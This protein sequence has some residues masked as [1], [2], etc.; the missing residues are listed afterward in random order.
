M[1]KN[2]MEKKLFVFKLMTL[3]WFFTMGSAT[4][5]WAEDDGSTSSGSNSTEETFVY[6]FHANPSILAGLGT[7]ITDWTS[8][9]KHMVIT[10]N[11][12]QFTLHNCLRT[13][14]GKSTCLTIRGD[15]NDNNTGYDPGYVQGSMKGTMTQMTLSTKSNS[16]EGDVSI[17]IEASD[18]KMSEIKQHIY[19]NKD[20]VI[21]IPAD[22]QI[23]DAKAITIQP[24]FKLDL[25]KIT[26]TRSNGSAD[27]KDPWIIF[28]T[29][30]ANADNVT[31]Y[32]TTDTENHYAYIGQIL[33]LE[34]NGIEGFDPVSTMANPYVVTYTVD[35][36]EPQFTNVM[37]GKKTYWKNGNDTYPAGYEGHQEGEAINMNGYVYRRGIVLG[38]E[39]DANGTLH[40]NN[41]G[42]KI[43]VRLGIFKVTFKDDGTTDYTKVKDITKVF[44]LKASDG[45]HN[46]PK[47]RAGGTG[48]S[49]QYDLQYT[50]DT[51]QKTEP[52]SYDK[53]VMPILDPN[54]RIKVF[55][56]NTWL[57]KGNTVIAKFSKNDNYD[58]QDLLNAS[59]TTLATDSKTL[60]SS[61]LKLRK[62]TAMQYT[63]EGIASETVAEGFYWFIPA[64]KQLYLE[65]TSGTDEDGKV[66]LDLSTGASKKEY[67]QITLKGYYLNGETKEYVDLSQIGLKKSNITFSDN[68]VA[69]IIK[70][71]NNAT[72]TDYITFGSDGKTASFYVKGVDNG[73]SQMTI[74]TEKT[75]NVTDKDFNASTTEKAISFLE[76]STHLDVNVSGSGN[77]MPP[78]VTPYSQTYGHEMEA[79]VKGY[80][81]ELDGEK[82][83]FY[84]LLLNNSTNNNT[85]LASVEGDEDNDDGLEQPSEP[86]NRPGAADI[87]NVALN[88]HEGDDPQYA[89]AGILEG[90]QKMELTIPGKTGANYVLYAVAAKGVQTENGEVKEANG[91]ALID[92]SSRVVWGEYTYNK[93]EE[94]VLTP[95]VIES[96][97][98]Y[99]F[100]GELSVEAHVNGD[101]V[102]IFY[103]TGNQE[104]RFSVKEDGTFDTNCS[105]YDPTSPIKLTASTVIRAIAYSSALG[106]TS[107]VVTYRYGNKN[108]DINEPHFSI[109]DKKFYTGSKYIQSLTGKKL[110]IH[111]TFYDEDGNEQSIGGENVDWDNDTYHIYYTT[112]GSYPTSNSSQYQGA[113]AT[114][115]LPT[116]SFE[117]H[118]V[119]IANGKNGDSS[120][121]DYSKLTVM[122]SNASYWETTTTNCPD[123]KLSSLKQAITQGEGDSQVTLVNIEFGGSKDAN[124]QELEWKHYASAEHGTGEPL[125]DIGTY[126]I[127]PA[128]DTDGEV[129]DV[130]DEMGNLWNHSKANDQSADFQTHKATYG[131]PASGAFVKFEPQKDGKLT[132]WCCQEGALYYNNNSSQKERYNEGFL[133]KRPAY[134]IDEAG[135]SYKPSSVTAAGVLSSNWFKSVTST[136]WNKKGD[137]VNGVKQEVFTS[138]QTSMI[139]YM[140][141]NVISAKNADWNTPLQPLIVYLNTEENKKVAGFN[142]AE[143]PREESETE[144]T[145][146]YTPDNIIDGTGVCIPS[147]SYMKYTFD[148]KAGK[149]YFFFGW[150]TKIGIRGFGFEPSETTETAPDFAIYSGNSATGTGGDSKDN[151]FTEKKGKFCSKVTL[152]RNFKR[153]TW[154]TLVLPFSVSASQVKAVFG[155]QTKV[156]HYRAIE[157]RTM[158]FFEH[159]HQM[160]VAGTPVLIK[161]MG[162]IDG[163]TDDATSIGNREFTNVTIESAEVIDKPCNDY[164]Y[165]GT[166]NTDYPMVGSYKPQHVADHNYYIGNDG[167]VYRLVNNGKGSTLYGTRAYIKGTDDNGSS[168]SLNSMAKAAYNNLT[169]TSMDGETTDIDFISAGRGNEDVEF[170]V[171]AR[172]GI[173][174]VDG[175][176]VRQNGDSLKGLAK[177][178]YIQDGKKLVVE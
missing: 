11:T 18:G 17:I 62:V 77:L 45:N 26:V 84:Y 2:I 135:K 137:E 14:S 117:I 118:A 133:R 51:K 175:K 21:K 29:Q 60:K 37:D 55:A 130:K 79:S 119:V 15:Y 4:S 139:Y 94:P 176:L 157:N 65:T 67:Q 103:V 160:I 127:A 66:S 24:N 64:R 70:D 158:Y 46:R 153:N 154:T 75:T 25:T 112:D 155:D 105:L 163:A 145:K 76:A 106:I 102:Q 59:N 104:L 178:I 132:I 44:T 13:G 19:K 57:N 12:F 125:N 32:P 144:A 78:T 38:I 100:S 156:L 116:G 164:G 86:Q 98:V 6:D 80:D 82:V 33:Q 5:A 7:S 3:L 128:K 138:E 22:K 113:I 151:D 110:C 173:Y 170:N 92:K 146:A 40:E 99:P 147:A 120:V 124:G 168:V 89:A 61:A 161:P 114:E 58:L 48:E 9:N 141:N 126:T 134:F 107:D 123:G 87:I 50:P 91:E 172:G 1:I 53:G 149:T 169:P 35:G 63:R 68:A 152:E 90:D 101:N 39:K 72:A 131:L 136:F 83:K 95:G 122:N 52:T 129:A 159:F 97:G 56:A 177:G 96:K 8:D 73:T 85:R 23:E 143:D 41:E 142:V 54:E 43:T 16:R 81:A 10:V 109:D 34:S 174:S 36:S 171:N 166:T 71:P 111:A 27:V 30:N 47:W 115:N 49:N 28:K 165:Q 93:L 167:K 162:H 88:F 20:N 150:M 148:V 74:K 42:D 31:R 121:S 108:T 69:E 140:F